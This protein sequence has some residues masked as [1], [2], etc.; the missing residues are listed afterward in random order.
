MSLSDLLPALPWHYSWIPAI[1]ATICWGFLCLAGIALIFAPA[2]DKFCVLGPSLL[3]ATILRLVLLFWSP[4][5]TAPADLPSDPVEEWRH[6]SWETEQVLARLRWDRRILEERLAQADEKQR[7]VF[8]SAIHEIDIQIAG[9][10]R[11]KDR[12]GAIVVEMER[13]ERTQKR[14]EMVSGVVSSERREEA[15]RKEVEVEGIR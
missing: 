1:L 12:L 13:R 15:I 9:V 3:Y 14:R 6:R 11:E 2:K 4:V 10:T 7:P 5:T 8:A